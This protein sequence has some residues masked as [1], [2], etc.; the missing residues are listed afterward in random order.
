[1]GNKLIFLSIALFLLIGFSSSA[2]AEECFPNYQCAPWSECQ[3][4]FR[5]RTC[6]DI[7]CGSKDT[8]ERSFCT[9][10]KC[11]PKI[12]CGDWGSCTYT[13]K[14]D[15]FIKGNISFEGYR[16]RVCDDVNNCIPKYMQEGQCEDSFKLRL[17]PIEQCGQN[18][19]AVI[20]P[21]SDKKVARINLDRWEEGKFDLAFVQGEQKYCPSC[22]NAVKDENENGVDCGGSC[23]PCRTERQYIFYIVTTFLWLGSLAFIFLSFRQYS[24]LKKPQ[25]QSQPQFPFTKEQ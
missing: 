15:D 20:D 5:T 11:T 4:G 24:R 2:L 16:T 9:N 21:L 10:E 6:S 17:S 23:K 22:Y 8:V 18:L 19:L 1:M 7:N 14:T 12:E 3:D 25:S 13:E